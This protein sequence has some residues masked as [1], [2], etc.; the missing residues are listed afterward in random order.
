MRRLIRMRKKLLFSA[1]FLGTVALMGA[2]APYLSPYSPE[3][4]AI[5]EKLQGPSAQHWMGTDTLGRDLYTR[6]LYGTRLSLSVGIVTALSALILGIFVGAIAG[7]RGG[8]IDGFLMRT[9]DLLM[10]FPSVLLAILLMVLFGR[11]LIGLFVAIAMTSWLSL[12]R[13]IRGQVLQAKALSYVEA[14]R[15]VGVSDPFI[16]FRHILPNLVGSMIVS[17][18]IQIPNNMMAESFLSFIGLGL[19]PPHASWGTLANEGFRAMQSY[20]HLILF[21]GG[22]LF[23]TLLA[24]NYLGEGF[25]ERFQ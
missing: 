1:L 17:L 10:I 6:I 13:L 2:F 5:S 21:P 16:L 9:V 11:G 14:A 8:W 24:F 22:I 19:Q 18:T 4:Q 3:Q 7:Y 15:A 23:M 20:P 12:A 25:R